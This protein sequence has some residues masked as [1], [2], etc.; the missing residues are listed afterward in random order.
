MFA[1]WANSCDQLEAGRRI[2]APASR[3]RPHQGAGVGKASNYN[4]RLLMLLRQ[5]RSPQ[6]GLCCSSVIRGAVH[7]RGSHLAAS[8]VALGG[9]PLTHATSMRLT[10]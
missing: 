8:L 5:D 2:L 7:S 6:L 4:V 3:K 1:A 9:S 10:Q